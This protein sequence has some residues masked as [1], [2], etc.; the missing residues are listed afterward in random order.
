RRFNG[1]LKPLAYRDDQLVTTHPIASDVADTDEAELGFDGITYEKGASVLKQLVA[2]IGREPFRDGVRAYFQRHAWDNATLA[3]FLDALASAAGRP[4][5]G[6]ARVWLSTASVNTIA[7]EWTVADGVIDHLMLRQTAPAD[8]PTLRPHALTLALVHETPAGLAITAVTTSIEGAVGDVS[9]ARGLPAPVFVFPNHGDHDYAKVI[10]DPVSMA[11]A[12][13]RLAEIDDP[14]LRQLAWSALWDMVRDARLRSTEYL[15]MVREQA[16]LER[17]VALLDSILEHAVGAIRRYLPD[18]V[19]ARESH[20]LVTTA[21]AALRSGSAD[22]DR[23]LWLRLAIAAAASPDDLARLLDIADGLTPGADLPIDQEMRW[24]LA[25]RQTALGLPGAA[26]R[27]E[28]ETAR[29]RSDRGQREMIRAG[30]AAP[31]AAVKAEAWVR[32]H[33][34]GYGSDYLTRAALSGFQWHH[35]RD[36]L[37][38]FREPFFD[39]VRQ[40]YRDRDLGYARSYLG[41]LFPSAWAE[42]PVL[43]RARQLLLDLGPDE[44]QLRRHLLEVCDDMERTIRVRAFAATAATT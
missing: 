40:V 4:L 42:P 27:V 19:R 5:D 30:V 37:L 8:H 44:V 3:D 21:L 11:F 17:D 41:A 38:P 6:W 10:L 12:R 14:L 36:L 25:V 1:V 29:D 9:G 16:P 23:R 20:A 18:D 22:D 43:E 28:I 7:A 13:D 15:A 26:A 39:E 2:T 24:Q 32:I 33:G 31:D 34:A 35:Q